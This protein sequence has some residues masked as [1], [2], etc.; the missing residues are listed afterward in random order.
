MNSET[1]NPEIEY[2]VIELMFES[3]K[4]HFKKDL[5][6]FDTEDELSKII[7]ANTSNEEKNEK[8][9]E[10]C[11]YWMLTVHEFLNHKMGYLYGTEREYFTTFQSVL[12]YYYHLLAGTDLKSIVRE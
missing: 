8:A 10:N 3:Y 4:E 11:Q 7:G 12:D 1:R 5:G 2:L 6:Q 9:W